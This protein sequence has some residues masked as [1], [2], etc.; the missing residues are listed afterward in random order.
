MQVILSLRAIGQFD[1]WRARRNIVK[2]RTFLRNHPSC[3]INYVIIKF[4]ILVP[5]NLQLRLDIR[6][7]AV[8][9]M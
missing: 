1:D 8:S 2:G 9:L 7:L 6:I 4:L 3:S 5:T